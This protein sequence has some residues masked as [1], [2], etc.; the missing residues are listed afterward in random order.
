MEMAC[1]HI[2]SCEL[3]PELTTNSALKVWQTFY[4]SGNYSKCERY[5]KALEGKAIPIT[6]LPNGKVLDTAYLSA[7]YQKKAKPAPA[8][9]TVPE[10]EFAPPQNAEQENTEQK[11]EVAAPVAAANSG[12]QNESLYYIRFKANGTG[13]ELQKQAQSILEELEI[14]VDA[15]LDKPVGDGFKWFILITDQAAEADIYRAAIR[16][17]ELEGIEGQVKCIGLESLP[18]NL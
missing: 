11:S 2:E 4:C 6:M 3:F 5:K 12:K 16:I 14:K 1:S 8:Q 10:A 9:P 7:K 17:E 18:A 13:E 15:V